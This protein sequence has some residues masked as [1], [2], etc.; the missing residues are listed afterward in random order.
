MQV[1]EFEQ[2][3]KDFHA[4]E[5]LFIE[6]NGEYYYVAELTYDSVRGGQPVIKIGAKV[7]QSRQ[8]KS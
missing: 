2:A 7:E 6:L 3:L 4:A 1:C 8:L 5:D